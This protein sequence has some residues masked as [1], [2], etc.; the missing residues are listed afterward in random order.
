M[1]AKYWEKVCCF[2]LKTA[3]ISTTTKLEYL[4]SLNFIQKN[5][6]NAHANY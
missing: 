5:S 3:Y 4:Y 6:N 1:Y 2:R